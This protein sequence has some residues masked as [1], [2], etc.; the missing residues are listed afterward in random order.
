MDEDLPNSEKDIFM[1]KDPR[2][3]M[4]H[5]VLSCLQSFTF[6][7]YFMRIYVV[8]EIPSENALIISIFATFVATA[9]TEVEQQIKEAG[10]IL[11]I[12]TF[13]KIMNAC[14][15]IMVFT[16]NGNVNDYF[17]GLFFLYSCFLGRQ[18]FDSTGMVIIETVKIEDL[19]TPIETD[20]LDNK[21]L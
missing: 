8:T 2:S 21:N 19:D 12:S 10:S 16:Y 14:L 7:M 4:S 9:E 3:M 15:T 1:Q 5:T 20:S 17:V 6:F 13:F 11:A 18:F